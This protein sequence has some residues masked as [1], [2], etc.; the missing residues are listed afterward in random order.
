MLLFVI[1]A[2]IRLA[3][4]LF[5]QFD[6]L[7]GQDPYA[8]Y[9]QAIAISQ[10]LPRG[11]PPPANFFWPNGYPLLAA[12][13]ML[14]AGPTPLAGQAV[15][16]LWGSILPPLL[17]FLAVALFGDRPGEKNSYL[18][19]RSQWAG[20]FA[21]LIV[22]VAGQPV[23]SSVVIM[24]DMPA[25][26]WAALS[27]WL[28]AY[29]A[30]RLNRGQS[31]SPTRLALF[32]T[33]AGMALGLAVTTRWIYGLVAPALAAFTLFHLDYPKKRWGLAALLLAV[34]LAMMLPQLWLS[35]N[36][37]AG[38]LHSWLLGWRPANFFRRSFNTIDGY[39]RYPLPVGLFYALPLAHPAYTFPLPGLAAVWAAWKLWQ[40]RQWGPLT[41]LLGWAAAVYLFLA[42]IPYQNFRFGLALYLPPVLLAGFGLS[43]LLHRPERT[44]TVLAR[45]AIILSVAGMLAWAYPMLNNF[46]T[47]QNRD[48]QI[49]RQVEQILPA[50]AV[51]LSFGLTLTLRHYTRLNTLELFYQDAASLDAL[52]RGPAPHYLLANPAN[53]RTQWAGKTPHQNFCWLRRNT[54]LTPLTGL[55]PYTLF[56]INPG[57]RK[58]AAP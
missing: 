44:A 11:L 22:A 54:T 27:A 21:G 31:I 55:P 33:A 43:D 14:L 3:T 9:H 17:Y 51:V 37:P 42:G 23:L 16:W 2:G 52:A 18:T 6:G 34:A 15:S 49:A 56:K 39:A 40:S 38:L 53:L 45:A 58:A 47:A 28:V 35:L 19:T 4:I 29:P 1:A 10:N 7:Y 57:R 25:L 41:L 36:K 12:L 20:L 8:Y 48:K 5:W 50:R 26:G 24:A 13:P 32:I 30:S 46:L